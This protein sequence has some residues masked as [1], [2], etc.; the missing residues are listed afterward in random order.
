MR[1]AQQIEVSWITAHRM[2]RKIR[3]AMGHRDSLYRLHDL[4]E[5]DNALVGAR[6][7]GKRSTEGKTP[8][9]VAVENRGEKAG[10]VAMEAVTSVTKQTV[11]AFAKRHFNPAQIVRSD[12]LASLSSL[13]ETQHHAARVTPADKAGEWLPWVHVTIGNLKTFLLGAYHGASGKYFRS[14]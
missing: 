6:R 10:Y 9:L 11:R 4:S 13:G 3:I 5:I 14:I 8:I 1:L 2:L 7:S 12:A